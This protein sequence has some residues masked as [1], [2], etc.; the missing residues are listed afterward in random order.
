MSVVKV[1]PWVDHGLTDRHL[2]AGGCD[3]SHLR[4]QPRGGPLEVLL[5]LDLHEIGLVTA[6]RVD[7]RRENRH[8]MGPRRKSFEVMTQ[9]LVEH[10]VARQERAEPGEL[11]GG[12]KLTVE[13]E[14]GRLDKRA[15]L[16]E[17]L[18]GI[19]TVLQDPFVAID[20]RDGTLARPRVSVAVVQGDVPARRSEIGNVDGGF[21]FRP[22]KHG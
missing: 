4:E 16:R 7:H 15:V 8:G 19:A 17:L 13:N 1:G 14:P 22:S 11:V 10:L 6:Q 3:G 2:V 20:V 21:I 5:A 9:A 12:R 18:D